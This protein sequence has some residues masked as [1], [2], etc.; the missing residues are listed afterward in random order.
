MDHLCRQPDTS[1]ARNAL[2]EAARI[3]RS[4]IRPLCECDCNS[5]RALI[6][7][8]GFGCAKTLSDFASRGAE[9]T[10]LPDFERV[11][12]EFALSKKPIGAIC[13]APF[14]VAKVL[15]GTKITLGKTSP[16]AKWP[17]SSAI[18]EARKIGAKI[19]ERDVTQVT[20]CKEHDV[21]S[22]PAWM[23]NGTYADVHDGIGRLVKALKK[24]IR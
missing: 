10:V 6:I 3:V 24:R 23:Y 11:I 7:P 1:G 5:G 8:G 21:F 2:V 14:F 13:L 22:T 9:C 15:C 19:E 12:T 17:H 20:H 4:E 16:P 18:A